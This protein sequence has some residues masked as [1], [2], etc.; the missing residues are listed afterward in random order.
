MQV[1]SKYLIVEVGFIN[2]VQLWYY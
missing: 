1:T 2:D